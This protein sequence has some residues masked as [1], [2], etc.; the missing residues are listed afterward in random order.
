MPRRILA[1]AAVLLFGVLAAT[2]TFNYAYHMGVA[3]GLAES[4]KLPAAAAVP[5][6]YH[7]HYGHGPFFFGPPLFVLL[8][9]FLLVGALRRAFWGGRWAHA[10]ACGGGVPPRFEEWHRR[11]HES[12]GPD[13][14]ATKV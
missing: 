14:G 2:A 13:A 4:G 7:G 12:M 11:A 8:F 1:V 3:E 6:L 5:Y 10:G 9:L